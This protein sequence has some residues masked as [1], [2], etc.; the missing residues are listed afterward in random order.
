MKCP[1]C[2]SEVRP[3][4]KYPGKYLCDTCKKRF[5]E[6]ALIIDEP[7]FDD[8]ND[9]ILILENDNFDV[10]DSEDEVKLKKKRKW[11]IVL[12]VLLL[13]I[14]LLAGAAAA[15]YFVFPEKADPILEKF[16]ID[17]FQEDAS[18]P[19]KKLV[20]SVY[21]V[22]ETANYNGISVSVLGYEES[23]GDEWFAPAEGNKFVFVN[24]KITNNTDEEIIVN[25]M[26]SFE[27]Y[28]G[29]I[30]LDYSANAF[31]ALATS[32]DKPKM[33]GNIAPGETLNGYL[34]LE[35][36]SDWTSLEIQY[37]DNVWTENK[38]RFEITK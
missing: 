18:K 2:G 23:D 12:L 14:L 7:E 30:K 28:C 37:A 20:S 22:G 15:V 38:I 11:P 16:G 26:A 17:L 8:D 10:S 13:I 1:V 31:T 29:D 33:D 24:M 4:K 6:S 5:P 9:D 19:N 32:T 3:S 25:S 36:P 21:S 34:S 27:N 35:V